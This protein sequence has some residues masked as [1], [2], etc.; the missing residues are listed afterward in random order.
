MLAAT[1]L[2]GKQYS[3]KIAIDSSTLEQLR[4]QYEGTDLEAWWHNRFGYG[5]DSLTESEGRYLL[6]TKDADKVRDRVT[7]AG[8]QAPTRSEHASARDDGS[9]PPD[10]LKFSQNN[11]TADEALQ[12]LNLGPKPDIID[13]T[14]IILN[15][16]RQVDRGVV[17]SWIDRVIKKANTEVLDALAPIK[18]AEDAAGV[19]EA[20][21][22][23]YVAARMAT[24]AA[25]TMQATMLYGLPEWQDGVIQRKAG[26]GEKDA[27]LGIFSDLGKDLHNWLGW[28]AGHRAE[29]L[30]GQGREN[31]LSEQ[32]HHGPKRPGQGEGSQIHG[33]QSA[34]E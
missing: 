15:Q 5:F 18:Y 1:A 20:A 9:L 11:A 27:L 26:T 28:M 34:L 13:K 16:L 17:S 30:M 31:L 2:T 7:A 29:I 32:G 24:G 19:T 4:D 25:S 8:P 23:G 6:R 22:S 33:G 14:K 10:G 21:D 3:A 12:K